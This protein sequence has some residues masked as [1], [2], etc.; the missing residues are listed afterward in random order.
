MPLVSHRFPCHFP[1]KVPE[2]H[3][4]KRQHSALPPAA[5]YIFIY[6]I[7]L[8]TTNPAGPQDLVSNMTKSLT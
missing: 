2:N 6:S 8:G 3:R 4:R 1:Q 5:G 7:K